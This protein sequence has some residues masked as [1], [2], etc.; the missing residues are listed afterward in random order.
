MLLCRDTVEEEVELAGESSLFDRV[1]A[2]D[3]RFEAVTVE[4]E[5]APHA[6]GRDGWWWRR[7]PADPLAQEYLKR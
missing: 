6:Q 4:V 3:V 5:D 2:L 7:L 1:D